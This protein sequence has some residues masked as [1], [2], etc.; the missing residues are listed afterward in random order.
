M[1]GQRNESFMFF[2]FYGLFMYIYYCSKIIYNCAYHQIE[3]YDSESEIKSEH[4]SESESEHGS[5]SESE[6]GSESESEFEDYFE[7]I[8]E[9]ITEEEEDTPVLRYRKRKWNSN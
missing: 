2:A 3:K 7:K 1:E 6:H 8:S 5:E 9:P 4:G